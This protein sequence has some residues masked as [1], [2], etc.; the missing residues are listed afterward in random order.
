MRVSPS[1]MKTGLHRTAA[2]LFANRRTMLGVAVVVV[3]SAAFGAALPASQQDDEAVY[4]NSVA[5][6][7]PVRHLPQDHL[8]TLLGRELHGSTGSDIG[9]VAGV[10]VNQ[11]GW[12]RAVVVDFGGFLGV[13][14]RKVA[15]DWRALRFDKAGGRARLAT[16]IGSDQLARAPQYKPSAK[17]VAVVSPPNLGHDP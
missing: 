11:I 13:G 14:V 12:P 6:G 3:A 10:L 4:W 7:V 16:D 9:T 15:V 17:S 2:E 5:N 8:F 1:T